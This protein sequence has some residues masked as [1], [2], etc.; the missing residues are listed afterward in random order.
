MDDPSIIVNTNLQRE[1]IN[2]AIKS[3]IMSKPGEGA[4]HNQKIW[5]PVY[6]SK[7]QKTKVGSYEGASHIR[8]TRDVGKEFKRGEIYRITK[9]D[10]DRAEL[11]LKNNQGLK[12]Y[13]P[14][15][16]GSGESFTQVYQQSEITLHAGDKV[17][18]RQT[19]KK[20]G[21]SNNDYG[22]IESISNGKII[23]ARDD[24]SSISLPKG[25]R[26]LGHLDHAWA[27][28]VYSFQGIT[29]TDNIAIMKADKNPLTTIDALYV[30]GCLLYTSPSPRDATLSRMPSS[31]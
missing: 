12:A 23:V 14:A 6:L 25:H 5:R 29:V 3:E 17:K 11:I 18:F 27:S 15:R 21:I 26:L 1:A 4:G 19:D 30:A 13:R 7:A 28:T 9:I 31:A 20:L 8:F 2:K 24:K 22:R 16:H 10:H